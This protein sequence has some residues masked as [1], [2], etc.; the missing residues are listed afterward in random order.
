M[1]QLYS[2]IFVLCA[3]S[4]TSSAQDDI[5]KQLEEQAKAEKEPVIATFKSTKIINM[6]T[7]ETNKKRNLDFRVSHLFGNIGEESGGGSHNLYG[8]DNSND[9]RIAFTYGITD[10]LMIGVSRCKRDENFEGDIKYKLVEQTT[11]NKV[12]LAITLYGQSSLSARE[13]TEGLYDKFV[14]RINHCAQ[15]II[16][17]KFSSNFSM[18]IVPSYVHRNIV[19]VYDEND[20]YSVGAGFR[21]KFTKSAAII[22]DYF[23]TLNRPEA[24]QDNHYDPLGIGF[25]I[26][27]GGHVFSVMFTNASGILENDFIPNTVDTWS[28][29][30]FKFA[31]NISRIFKL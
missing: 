29:G 21:Y 15:L 31:F 17:R 13:N 28:K 18:E 26:E 27:T 11:D 24:T 4:L 25:E 30:G 23:Y 14:H 9:I 20:L 5:M 12:P 16:A 19:E 6:Q 7:N 8:L 10:K 22:A 3:L 1:K 2:L